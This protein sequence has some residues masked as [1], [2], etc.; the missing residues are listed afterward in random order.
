MHLLN[1][2]NP[3]SIAGVK[4]EQ[5]QNTGAGSSLWRTEAGC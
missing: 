1:E 5:N 2:Y 4:V 3:K